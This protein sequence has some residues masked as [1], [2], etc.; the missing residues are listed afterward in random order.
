MA[1]T[2]ELS[3]RGIFVCDGIEQ[4]MRNPKLSSSPS[5]TLPDI[6]EVFAVHHQESDTKFISDVFAFDSRDGTLVEAVL[7]IS[8]QRVSVEGMRK[9]LSRTASLEF[10]LSNGSLP[11]STAQIQPSKPLTPMPAGPPAFPK[12]VKKT[13]K[14]APKPPEIGRAHV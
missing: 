7:G 5:S 6:W 14:K 13:S 8:Y 2:A 9:A 12:K 11:A 1:D 4:W 3:E 10:P